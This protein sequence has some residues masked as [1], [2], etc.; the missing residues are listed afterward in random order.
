[1]ASEGGARQGAGRPKGSLSRKHVE[2]LCG[3]VSEGITPVEYMLAIMRDEDRDE[4]ARAWAAEKAAPYIHPRPAPL[5]RSIEIE[6]PDTSTVQG[7]SEAL[8]RITQAAA[9]G[10]I[11]PSEAQSLAALVEAQRKAIETEELA[12]RI[13]ALEQAQ[14]MRRR[15]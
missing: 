3:A 6:L 4:K 9:T 15:A 5:A 14:H 7:V 2:I 8:I 1:M 13:Q 11:S 12:E 10:Q